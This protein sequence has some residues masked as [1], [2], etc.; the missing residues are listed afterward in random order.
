MVIEEI[1]NLIEEIVKNH[2]MGISYFGDILTTSQINEEKLVIKYQ[3]TEGSDM[4]NE[5]KNVIKEIVD[6]HYA[7]KSGNV[8][9]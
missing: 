3:T 5:F 6:D 2:G 8:I 9:C 1:E 7:I 4:C